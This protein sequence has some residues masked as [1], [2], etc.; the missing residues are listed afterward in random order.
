[1]MKP[2]LGCERQAGQMIPG[3]GREID[4]EIAFALQQTCIVMASAR[5][6][7]VAAELR[8]DDSSDTLIARADADL[9]EQRQQQR[10]R[11]Q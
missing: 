10:S 3:Q 8:P 9:Y 6:P 7:G 1:M 5:M 11:K 2:R 4:Q